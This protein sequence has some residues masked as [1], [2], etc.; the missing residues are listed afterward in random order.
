MNTR[1][2]AQKIFDVVIPH[3]LEPGRDDD[4]RHALVVYGACEELG[5]KLKREADGGFEI[6]VITPVIDQLFNDGLAMA[7]G[8]LLITSGHPLSGAT[9]IAGDIPEGFPDFIVSFRE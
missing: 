4:T 9:V 6:M 5:I 1:M 7:I 8:S 2:L 3:L